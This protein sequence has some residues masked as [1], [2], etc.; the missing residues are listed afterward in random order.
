MAVSLNRR[1]EDENEAVAL[2]H[3]DITVKVVASFA[4]TAVSGSVTAG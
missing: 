2:T 4:D 1:A 3:A